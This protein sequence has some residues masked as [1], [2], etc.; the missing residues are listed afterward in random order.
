MLKRRVDR[1]VDQDRVLAV[2]LE[3][4]APL[5]QDRHRVE[6]RSGEPEVEHHE[7]LAGRDAGVDHRRQLGRWVVHPAR[8]RRLSP[9]STAASDAVTRRN[10][11]HP[12]QIERSA[13][14]DD[15]VPGLLKA[16]NVVVP[17]NAAATESWK[18]RSGSPSEATRRVGMYIDRARQDEQTVASTTSPAPAASRSDPTRPSSIAPPRTATSARR[19]PAAVTTV[20][21]GS[22]VPARAGR[23]SRHPPRIAAA[24]RRSA[25]RH[26]RVR[27]S[28]GAPGR[29]RRSSRADERSAWI[30]GSIVIRRR[31]ACFVGCTPSRR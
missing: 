29:G 1:G 14:G 26:R 13:A 19:D 5:A 23:S 17:P 11:L 6:D 15:P 30:S 2:D 20:P 25:G 27:G 24:Q 31:R 4:A 18:K 16:R 12:G 22:G 28:P 8:D 21:P 9:K 10:S 7:R 3:H